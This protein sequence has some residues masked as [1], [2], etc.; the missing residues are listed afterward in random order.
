MLGAWGRG[1]ILVNF[2]KYCF[3]I[4][5]ERCSSKVF[6]NFCVRGLNGNPCYFWDSVSK[7]YFGSQSTTAAEQCNDPAVPE[8][9]V[10]GGLKPPMPSP[11]PT[12][13][14]PAPS[15]RAETALTP[16]PPVGPGS[17]KE[18]GFP[19]PM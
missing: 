13:C 7:G 16:S 19:K 17:E 5:H 4:S 12:S 3:C 11:A 10:Q 9:E 18:L 14:L 6:L 15:I 8:E 2:G 1:A